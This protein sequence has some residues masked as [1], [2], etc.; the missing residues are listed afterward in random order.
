MSLNILLVLPIR[1]GNN[2]QIA[3]DLGIIVLA[4]ALQKQGC[5]V[6]LLDCPKEGM[7][8]AAFKQFLKSAE[9][10]VVGFRCY[11][12]DHNYVKHHI[13]IVRQVFPQA[14]TLVGGPHSSALPDFVL[15]T[16]PD[17]DFD[18]KSEA[19]EGL[20]KLIALIEKFGRTIPENLLQDIPGLGWRSSVQKK[21]V[22][23]NPGFTSDLDAYGIPAWELIKP[24][25][26][27]GFIYNEYYPLLTTRGCPYP[28]I[29]CN[30][31]GLSGK[32]LRH[33]SLDSVFEELTF[34]KNR[35]GISRFSIVDDEFTLD[36]NYAAQFCERLIQSG[37]KLRW[38]CP[39]G[40]RLDSLN[41]E[42]L[43]K[44]E[45]SG[46]ECI[47]VGIE[48]GSERVQ[49]LIGKQITVKK[50]R[51][52]A[53]MVAENSSIRTIGY[54]ML[55][56]P[57]ETEEEI[58]QTINLATELPLYRANF[59][60]VIPVPGTKL[61]AD[62]LLRNKLSLDKINWDACTTEQVSF[63][64]DNLSHK[65][66][67]QLYRLAYFRF[68]GRPRVLWQLA[69]ASLA[70]THVIWASILNLKRLF[71][72]SSSESRVPLYIREAEV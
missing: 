43:R 65:R 2:L 50:I 22:I 9:F 16:M 28:C 5:T 40:L 69:K 27:P 64:R 33:R 15:D 47:A 10:D 39:V 4:T 6:T 53:F 8:F 7:N 70:D 1:E 71:S 57:D 31:P 23:N 24:D 66:L 55:G 62:A 59:S 61:F 68:Y 21:N 46:C 3:P 45:N 14:I 12:R 29:Y 56:F 49:K 63:E 25:T 13:K 54:F 42:L 36:Q 18:W 37:L 48:S 19:E 38:D 41:P 34:L 60:L 72:L 17:L 35:Y 52:Q 32:K 58:M 67:L 51:Q 26:Y 20:P 44:M 11:S 30:T